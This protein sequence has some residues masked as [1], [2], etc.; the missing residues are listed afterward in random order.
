MKDSVAAVTS[1]TGASIAAGAKERAVFAARLEAIEEKLDSKI[2]KA[3]LAGTTSLRD[4][5]NLTEE[6]VA[7]RST[8]AHLSSTVS[9]KVHC[10]LCLVL[11]FIGL[12]YV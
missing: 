7:I 10:T 6:L 12:R 2:D 11:E 9:S 4:L 8:V 1:E 3:A 5:R